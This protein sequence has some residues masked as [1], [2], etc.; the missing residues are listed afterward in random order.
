MK[1]LVFIY[2]LLIATG[3]LIASNKHLCLLRNYYLKSGSISLFKGSKIKHPKYY[4]WDNWGFQEDSTIH[5]YS[6][7]ANRNLTP[8]ERHLNAHWRHFI[9]KDGGK[10]W[11]DKGPVLSPRGKGHD[12]KAIWSGS[13]AKLPDGKY[14]ASYTG[15]DPSRDY[16]QSISFAVSDDAHNF[17]RINPDRPFMSHEFDRK[18][19]EKAGYYVDRP[20]KVGNPDGEPD[21]A[22]QALRDPFIVVDEQNKM[23]MYWGAKSVSTDG[24]V[25]SSIG[26]AI[27][28]DINTPGSFEL[29]PPINPTDAHSFNQ[30]ELP[31]V[32]KGDDGKYYWVISTTNRKS[33]S[34]LESEIQ[35]R[36]RMYRSDS[37]EGPIEP[38]GNQAVVIDSDETR[39]YAGNIVRDFDNPVQS[40]ESVK[41]RTFNIDD[42]SIE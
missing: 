16:L 18:K 12:G 36:V 37:L 10:S 7:A 8:D 27:I 9:S 25:T 39:N 35:M 42:Y 22:I 32:F 20:G 29:L 26:H 15:I 21:G 40:P 34:Q 23:H 17:K 38:Y 24:E 14:L 6:M 31:N 41:L 5:V 28:K 30:V 33:Q 11:L 1:L 19:F 3:Q 2:C 4:L 13:I